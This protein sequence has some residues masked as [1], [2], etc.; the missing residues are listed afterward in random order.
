M[1]TLSAN[2]AHAW[3]KRV[4]WVDC[5]NQYI[6]RTIWSEPYGFINV[7]LTHAINIINAMVLYLYCAGNMAQT[8]AQRL[9]FGFQFSAFSPSRDQPVPSC[10]T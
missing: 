8:G 3:R 1:D 9:R 2:V 6:F 5:L 10:F 4:R 7:L